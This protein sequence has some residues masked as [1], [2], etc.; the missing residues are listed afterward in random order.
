MTHGTPVGES[1]HFPRLIGKRLGC[2]GFVVE[3][4]ANRCM[5]I[6]SGHWVGCGP[7]DVVECSKGNPIVE[8]YKQHDKRLKRVRRGPKTSS[9]H[10]SDFQR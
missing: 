9:P 8:G 7:F 10:G 2:R 5:V 6:A 3:S 1:R 4:V